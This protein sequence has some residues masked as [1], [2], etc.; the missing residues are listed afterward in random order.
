MEDVHDGSDRKWAEA[1]QEVVI[2]MTREMQLAYQRPGSSYFRSHGYQSQRQL[3]VFQTQ[4]I[5]YNALLP[6]PMRLCCIVHTVK[7]SVEEMLGAS[8]PVARGYT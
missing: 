1:D 4:K 6:D 7:S 8:Q 3:L 5:V 2:S